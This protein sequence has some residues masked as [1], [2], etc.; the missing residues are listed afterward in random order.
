MSYPVQK[1][2]AQTIV[3]MCRFPSAIKAKKQQRYDAWKARQ[4]KQ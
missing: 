1:A 4:A 3:E 2:K